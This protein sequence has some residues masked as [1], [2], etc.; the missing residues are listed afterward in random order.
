MV[1]E[2]L[3][4]CIKLW[5]F[6]EIRWSSW[7]DLFY[8]FFNVFLV[9]V[10]FLEVLKEDN[11]DKVVKYLDLIF[12]FDFIIVLVVVEYFISIIVVFFNYF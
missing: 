8:I 3:E 4:K 5:I 2:K 12:K 11:D 6:C 7:V 10:L 9:V 1:K